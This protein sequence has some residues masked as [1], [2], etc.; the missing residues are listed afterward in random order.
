MG[1]ATLPEVS[2]VDIGQLSLRASV[3]FASRCAQRVF[4]LLTRA[5]EEPDWLNHKAALD[6]AL[7]V[8]NDFARGSKDVTDSA[9]QVAKAAYHAAEAIYATTQFAGYAAAHAAQSA[10]SAVQYLKTPDEDWAMEVMAGT[11]GALRVLMNNSP[12]GSREAIQSALRQDYDRLAGHVV[13]GSQRLGET[14]DPGET[15]PLGSLWPA[16]QPNMGSVVP[17]GMF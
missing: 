11:F 6:L 13:K 3:A 4:P 9:D 14:I 7:A 15:G 12:P 16:G 17:F 1:A 10:A 8:A 2:M 5:T